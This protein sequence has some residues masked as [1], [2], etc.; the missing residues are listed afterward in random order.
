L[1]ADQQI[2][3]S[4]AVRRARFQGKGY[5]APPIYSLDPLVAASFPRI[6]QTVRQG[7]QRP[8]QPWLLAEERIANLSLLALLIKDWLREEFSSS[9]SASEVEVSL[10]T[11]NAADW[12]WEQPR[13]YSLLHPQT[14][15]EES[16]LY[17]AIPD[18]LAKD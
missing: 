13:T 4:L 9:L 10:A 15:E 7:W 1:A 17:N 18:F 14:R 12:Q 8:N 11:L 2:A 3:K 6:I 16:V 5:Q